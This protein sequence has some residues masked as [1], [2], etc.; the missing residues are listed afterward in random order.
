[1]DPALEKGYREAQDAIG[2]LTTE[3]AWTAGGERRTY[4][5]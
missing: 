1:M 5:F 3:E 2:S 4:V